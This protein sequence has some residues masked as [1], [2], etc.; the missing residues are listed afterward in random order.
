MTNK[1][2]KRAL[3][4]SVMALL[5]CFAMLMGTTMAWFT[6]SVSN[7]INKIQSGN[8][9]VELWHIDYVNG[10]YPDGFELV[11]ANTALFLN[12]DQQPILWEPGAGAAEDFRI[13]NVGSLALKYQF[14]INFANAT[15][16]P[17][18]KTLAD[19]LDVTIYQIGGTFTDEQFKNPVDGTI[20]SEENAGLEDCM[21]EGYL[22]PGEDIRFTTI[23][24]WNPSDID[25]EYNVEGGL[26]IDLGVNLVATQYTYEKDATGD[27]YDVDAEYPVIVSDAAS[28][29][30]AL[31]SSE[32]AY[33]KLTDAFNDPIEFSA[34]I[35]N[36][37]IDADGKNVAF[38]FTGNLEN[39]V[40]TGIVDTADEVPAVTV[41]SATT[42]EIII[43]NSVLNS[44]AAAPYG[45]I[46]GNGASKDLSVTVENCQLVSGGDKYGAYITNGNDF[47]FKNCT[48]TGF[49]S[50]AILINGTVTGNIVVDGCTFEDCAG[51]LKAGV[52][53]G[54][55]WQTGT[56]GNVTFTNNI[57]NNNT[58]KDG[59]YFA[60]NSVGTVTVY[61]NTGNDTEEADWTNGLN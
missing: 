23:I 40:V 50:W 20:I 7:G 43:R 16:T 56:T 14:S 6:D 36:K 18:G 30:A 31:N 9:D 27:Q 26:S 47:V 55:D 19:I 12:Q 39:V 24:N 42:G 25:N 10:D 3:F 11:E 54:A 15:E 17:E 37:T 1:T 34:D 48:F 21:I 49:K 22:L 33:I 29:E 28:L 52:S 61:G 32:P 59:K 2:T 58:L 4:S 8:L 13:K 57:L 51:I 53:G 5:L 38:K 35:A 44:G 46:A 60:T 41:T 45:A